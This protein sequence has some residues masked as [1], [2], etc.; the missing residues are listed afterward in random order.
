MPQF[1]ISRPIFAWVVALFIILMGT[2]AIPNLPIAQFPDVAPPSITI[3]ATYPGASAEVVNESVTSLIEQELN[4]AKGLMYFSSQSDS[5]GRSTITATFEPGTDPD[6]ASV[7]VQ[8]R[9]RRAEPRL[10]VAV[11]S[12]GIDVEQAS[13]N[14]L[15]IVTISSPDNTVPTEDLADYTTRNILDELKRVPGV[16]QAQ[17]YASSRA[18]R[19]WV[20]PAKLVGY[21]LSMSDVNAAVSTQ[22]VQVPAGSIGAPPVPGDQQVSASIIVQGLL[23]TPQEFDAIVLRSNPDG[24]KVYLRDV[25]RAEVGSENYQFSSRLNGQPTVAVAIQLATGANA[26]ATADFIKER[27]AALQQYFPTGI[28][29]EIPYDTSPFVEASIE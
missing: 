29:W 22:N 3:N 5:Y 27:M 2:L 1:F 28:D 13:S 11:M 6:L 23:A 9:I 15:L 20:D 8:N 25:A 7:D 19:I 12:Q 17:L 14:F 10:P 24:S 4:G 21:Q 26:L 16:G 18:M